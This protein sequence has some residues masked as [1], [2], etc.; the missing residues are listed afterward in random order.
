MIIFII[1]ILCIYLFAII[2]DN[3]Y[4]DYSKDDMINMYILRQMYSNDNPIDMISD[5]KFIEKTDTNIVYENT[6]MIK[7]LIRGTYSINDIIT[8]SKYY[9]GINTI[10]ESTIYKNTIILLE[11][12][13]NKKIY[14]IGHSLGSLIANI[15]MNET[16]YN[17]INNKMLSFFDGLQSIVL[18]NNTNIINFKYDIFSYIS[19]IKHKINTSMYNNP[20][21]INIYD[22]VYSHCCFYNNN[23][24]IKKI[25]LLNFL[26]IIII[27]ITL[28]LYY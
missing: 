27:S 3:P 11:K 4:N 1:I 14:L 7:F 9:I 26:F 12:Y 13:K 18:N 21:P 19:L 24:I 15:I 20:I 8:I 10:K 17:F 23:D 28:F 6:D 2:T 5:Y 16:D 22:I 25:N